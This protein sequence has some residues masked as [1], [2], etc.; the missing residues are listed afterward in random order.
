[1][2]FNP[3]VLRVLATSLLG[4]LNAPATDYRLYLDE[5]LNAPFSAIDRLPSF[6]LASAR[7]FDVSAGPTIGGSL[8]GEIDNTTAGPPLFHVSQHFEEL[9]TQFFTSG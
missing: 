7:G 4:N 3:G 6:S 2:P 8:P 5:L 1:M 9:L